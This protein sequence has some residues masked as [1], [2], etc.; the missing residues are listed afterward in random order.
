MNFDPGRK[1]GFLNAGVS[2]GSL[3]D[4]IAIWQIMKQS[5]KIPRTILLCV[6]PQALN[7]LQQNNRWLAIAEYYQTFFEM[8]WSI[9][10]R[11]AALTS[12][13]KDLLS[14]QTTLA[15]FKQIGKKRSQPRLVALAQYDG[16]GSVRLPSF[17]LVYP[18]EYEKKATAAVESLARENGKGEAIAFGIWNADDPEY[19][20]QLAL[21]LKDMQKNNVR[22]SYFKT[23]RQ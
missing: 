7:R 21:L 15:S 22:V 23:K 20:N 11:V 1:D 3:K 6:D 5:G 2:A 16:R 18:A 14:L 10:Y 19:F 12:Q 13:L 17:A 4:Y 9:R 8:G